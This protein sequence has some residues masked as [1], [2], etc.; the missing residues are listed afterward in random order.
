MSHGLAVPHYDITGDFVLT[1]VLTHTAVIDVV[2]VRDCL[3]VNH[4]G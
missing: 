3:S 2:V 1:A 4:P